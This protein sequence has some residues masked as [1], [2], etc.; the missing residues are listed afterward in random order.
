MPY[1][2]TTFVNGIITSSK[3]IINLFVDMKEIY[4]VSFLYT[5]RLNQ[6]A[7][8]HSFGI[9]R[10]MGRGYE[11][12]DPVSFKYRMRQFILSKK[13]VLVS[14]NPNT[15]PFRKDVFVVEGIREFQNCSSPIKK[16]V[17]ELL[18][19]D[20]E[21]NDENNLD[22]KIVECMSLD[23]D[24]EEFVVPK[25]EVD[26][27]HY[28]LGFVA[29]KFK[30]KYPYFCSKEKK[31]TW[32]ASKDRGGLKHMN[33]DFLE[34]FTK[35]EEVFRNRHLQTLFAESEAIAKLTMMAGHI[36]DIPADVKE[37]YLRCRIYFR[38]KTL[39]KALSLEKTRKKFKK[40][41]K[42]VS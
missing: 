41:K 40:M 32:V 33:D 9:L 12:P 22:A 20:G 11:H 1:C 35:L 5:R 27:F 13:H 39:N 26:G 10:Q 28:V 23:E 3:S 8:E 25:D 38:V 6:D 24:F 31:N 21:R 2:W 17:G 16:G 29:F 18:E 19:L 7:L 34:S 37:Y 30:D 15:L 14:I 4:S 42:I 36:K